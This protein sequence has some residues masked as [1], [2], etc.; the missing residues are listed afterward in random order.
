MR[1]TAPALADVLRSFVQR[2]EPPQQSDMAAGTQTLQ[3]YLGSQS[4]ASRFPV[5]NSFAYESTPSGG[6]STPSSTGATRGTG[7]SNNSA[8]SLTDTHHLPSVMPADQARAASKSGSSGAHG[9]SSNDSQRQQQQHHGQQQQQHL[10]PPQQQ[11]FAQRNSQSQYGQ[12]T[13]APYLQSPGFVG[14]PAQSS[15][16]TPYTMAPPQSPVHAQVMSPP[17]F[18]YSHAHFTPSIMAPSPSSQFDQHPHPTATPLDNHNNSYHPHSSQYP[19]IYAGSPVSQTFY[20][21]VT[22]A[23]HP[24]S[25]AMASAPSF[26]PAQFAQPQPDE[27]KGTWWYIPHQQAYES[28]Q[29]RTPAFDPHTHTFASSPSYPTGSSSHPFGSSSP[30]GTSSYQQQQPYANVTP[31]PL[32]SDSVNVL[33]GVGAAPPSSSSVPAPSSPFSPPGSSLFPPPTSPLHPG[34]LANS[35]V[36]LSGAKGVKSPQNGTLQSPRSPLSRSMPPQSPRSPSTASSSKTNLT[37]LAITDFASS[38]RIA[39]SPASPA[40]RQAYHPNVATTRSEWVMWVGNVPSDALEDELFAFFCSVPIPPS[41]ALAKDVFAPSSEVGGSSSSESTST[42]TSAR[43]ATTRAESF[44][45]SITSIF[46]IARS[47]CAFV[48]FSTPESLHLAVGLFN[49]LSLRPNDPRCPRLVCRIRKKDDDLRAGVGAQR[50]TGI[51]TRWVREQA[52][53][54]KDASPTDGIG[55]EVG[56]GKLVDQRA[57]D[58]ERPGPYTHPHA[59]NQHLTKGPPGLAS[60]DSNK[61]SGACSLWSTQRHNEGILDQAYRTSKDVFLI[62]SANKSGEFFGYARM[63]GP[64]HPKTGEPPTPA[65]AVNW[66]SRAEVLNHIS[67]TSLRGPPL[68]DVKEDDEKPESGKSTPLEPTLVGSEKGVEPSK[69]A[70]DPRPTRVATKAPVD[71][72]ASSTSDASRL[73]PPMLTPGSITS[74]SPQ[75]FSPGE[76]RFAASPSPFT[77]GE[78]TDMLDV[79]KDEPSHTEHPTEAAAY[80]R[81]HPRFSAPAEIGPARSPMSYHHIKGAETLDSGDRRRKREEA[82]GMSFD[83]TPSGSEG[84]ITGTMN[85]PITFR[86]DPDGADKAARDREAKPRPTLRPSATEPRLVPMPLVTNERQL[87]APSVTVESKSSS[88]TVRAAEPA[89]PEAAAAAA[90]DDSWGSPFPIEWVCTTGLP[91]PRTRHLRNPWNHDREIKVSRDGT[92]LEPAVGAQLLEEWEQ[93]AQV[94][95]PVEPLPQH[96]GQSRRGKS[97]AKP[98]PSAAHVLGG[99]KPN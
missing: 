57:G 58:A 80:G 19:P 28:H 14:Y 68:P 1:V 60:Q 85:G 88:E 33:A 35:S 47:N 75:I 74:K 40:P 13:P 97:R 54:R 90:E 20:P 44:A 24:A 17:H 93:P 37:K 4:I 73:A 10:H 9:T 5:R 64:I 91:F 70:T 66:Q 67:P 49:G 86:L 84:L 45:A 95:A 92:E 16:P 65:S 46:L 61:S 71:V 32:P 30:F 21:P 69:A 62:F 43:S 51:H 11:Q 81:F 42:V 2:S 18:A 38:S 56:D 31:V 36:S 98:I 29:H 79:R 15:Y 87:G 59:H 96:S 53:I 22:Y 99:A 76:N 8:D 25:Y 72:K 77:E 41:T 39:K 55:N 83:P 27:S 48:N 50:G 82:A 23:H 12:G 89:A 3:D 26:A 94:P 78:Q 7:G 63:A 34:Y 6:I 52:R